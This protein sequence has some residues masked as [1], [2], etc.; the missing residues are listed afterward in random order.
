MYKLNAYAAT[1]YT[2]IAEPSIAGLNITTIVKAIN[3]KIN[4]ISG[5]NS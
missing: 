4:L 2:F 5:E 3:A 1:N